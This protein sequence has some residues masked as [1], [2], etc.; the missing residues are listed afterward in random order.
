[1][2]VIKVNDYVIRPYS[3]SPVAGKVVNILDTAFPITVQWPNN[4]YQVYS[5]N[6]L[7]V[8]TKED[9]PEYFI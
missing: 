2:S 5:G 4:Y 8:V 6:Y 9:N 1:M 3:V 7:K